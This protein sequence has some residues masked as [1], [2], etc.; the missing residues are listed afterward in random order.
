MPRARNTACRGA[1]P[2]GAEG[3]GGEEELEH[4]ATGAGV[5]GALL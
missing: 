2:E 3:V 5:K 1:D 4:M